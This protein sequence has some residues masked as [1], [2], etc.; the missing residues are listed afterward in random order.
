MSGRTE[1]ALHAYRKAYE[2]EPEHPQ[3][4]LLYA[5]ALACNEQSD[6]A[7]GIIDRMIKDAPSNIWTWI[8]R[9]YRGALLGERRKAL[10][11]AT[12]ELKQAARWNEQYS[13]HMAECYVLMDE[14]AQA[15]EWLEN[16]IRRGFINFPFL[17]NAAPFLDGVREDRRFRQLMT[18]VKRQ[19]NR[20]EM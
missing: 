1:A 9:F 16:A 8:G 12:P 19:W 11:A 3:L 15:L 5:Y 13:F 17:A 10:R 18:K 7:F 4:R 2:L 14:P 6:E 20:F